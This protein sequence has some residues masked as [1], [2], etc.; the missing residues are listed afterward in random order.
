V[1]SELPARH[2]QAEFVATYI[3]RVAGMVILVI[4]PLCFGG[5]QAFARRAR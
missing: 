5:K 3:T 1:A 2:R 4:L